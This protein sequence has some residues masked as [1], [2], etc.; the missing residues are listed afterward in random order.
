MNNKLEKNVYAVAPYFHKRS[1]NFKFKAYQGWIEAGGRI[2]P[3]HYL[4]RKFAK[5]MYDLE[6]PCIIGKSKKEARLRFVESVSLRFDTFPDYARY[7]II[8]VIWDC[9]PKVFEQT[10]QWLAKHNVRTAIFTSAQTSELMRKRFP[11]M[12]ILT[13]TEGIN[14]KLYYPG[15]EL[16]SR[17]I[18]ILE[19]GRS[20]VDMNLPDRISILKSCKKLTHDQL[21]QKMSEA[22]VTITLPQCVT[23]PEKAGNIETL[24][25]RYWEAMLSR[26]VMIGNAPKELTDLLGYNPVININRKNIE[27]QV[28]DILEHIEDYQPLVDKNRDYAMRMASWVLRMQQIME[29]LNACG[30]KI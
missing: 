10:C 3:T 28:L 24:T 9:W 17:D 1:N 27:L 30:Y 20:R 2:A 13:I 12:N 25:Q 14:T 29:F 11:Q 6:L 8:P 16:K 7:E 5:I 4:P 26:M 18:D 22:K 21:F 19:Y 15:T 23:N